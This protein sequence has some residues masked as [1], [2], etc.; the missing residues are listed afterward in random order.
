MIVKYVIFEGSTPYIN[1][2]NYLNVLD[3]RSEKSLIFNMQQLQT[4]KNLHEQFFA[5]LYVDF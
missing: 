2:L 5:V 3:I 1:G 4:I